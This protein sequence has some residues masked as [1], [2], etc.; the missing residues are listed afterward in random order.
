MKFEFLLFNFV[1]LFSLLFLENIYMFLI[2]GCVWGCQQKQN[3]IKFLNLSVPFVRVCECDDLLQRR[4]SKVLP[5]YS[6][7]IRNVSKSRD[8]K[9]PMIVTKRDPSSEA[10]GGQRLAYFT[11]MDKEQQLK[12]LDI[13][14]M[15]YMSLIY[16]IAK[17][18]SIK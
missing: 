4:K 12:D 15:S 5:T 18:L 6:F 3:L 10:M 11:A 8:G 2:C 17:S 14:L 13:L 1:F 16:V 9:G 7:C